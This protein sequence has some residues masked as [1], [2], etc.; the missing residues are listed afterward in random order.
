MKAHHLVAAA[1]AV[2]FASAASAQ[3]LKPGLWE[4]TNKMQTGSG[5]MEQQMAEMQKQMAAMPP[6]Q[7]KMM[8]EMMAQRGM[9]MGGNS[10]G[11]MTVKV[12]MTKEMVERNELPAQQGDCKTTHQ[13]RTGNTMKMGFSCT[14]PPSTGEGQVVF[15]SPESYSMKMAISTTVQGKAEKVNMDGGGKWLGADCGSIKPMVPPKK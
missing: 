8:E 12:C 15:T 14:N 3:N 9:K 2:A 6:E 5:Q 7:R 4:I 10:A 13:S 1:C 11:G